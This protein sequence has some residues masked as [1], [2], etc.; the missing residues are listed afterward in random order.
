MNWTAVLNSDEPSM[1]S[2]DTVT[3]ARGEAAASCMTVPGGELSLATGHPGSTWV[4]SRIVDT[5]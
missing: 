5:M 2:R 4:Y 1:K 3:R